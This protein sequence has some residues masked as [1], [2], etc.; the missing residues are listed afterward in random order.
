MT[1]G[2]SASFVRVGQSTDLVDSHGNVVGRL[3]PGGQYSVLQ[4]QQGWYE[5]RDASGRTG[6]VPA[7]AVTVA[8]AQQPAATQTGE[9]RCYVTQQVEVRSLHDTN[10]VAGYLQPGTWYFVREE[11]QGWFRISDGARLEGWAPADQIR[12]QEQAA[13]PAPRQNPPQPQPWPEPRSTPLTRVV[14][15]EGM[16]AWAAP[17]PQGGVV[18]NLAAGTPLAVIDESGAWAHVRAAN[19]WEGWVDGRRLQVPAA[20]APA[21]PTPTPAPAAPMPTPAPAVS[22]PS[23]PSASAP[24]PTAPAPARAA[25][26]LAPAS[27]DVPSNARDRL[28]AAL[29]ERPIPI[30]A[31]VALL[32]AAFVGWIGG[33]AGSANG[34]DIPLSFLYSLTGTSNTLNFGLLFLVLAAGGLAVTVLAQTDRSAVILRIIG[35]VAAAVGVIFLIQ[36]S[37]TLAQLDGWGVIIPNLF[38]KGFAIGPYLAIAAGAALLFLPH[39]ITLSE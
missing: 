35:G 21:A 26:T 30:A 20:S 10:S 31:S 7:D 28:L 5:T 11:A 19:G 6:W 34:F 1:N 37:R 2:S 32:I 39:R 12:H 17:D 25:P 9:R 18:A 16:Q 8:E 38:F 13:S 14:P 15:P 33:Y 23:A 27:T 3:E 4:S 36:F 22:T 24:A 29:K